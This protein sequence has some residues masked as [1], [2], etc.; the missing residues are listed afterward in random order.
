MLR[1]LLL[2]AEG[3]KKRGGRYT[4]GGDARG[5]AR[6]SHLPAATPT[7]PILPPPSVLSSYP[8]RLDNRLLSGSA[9]V[10]QGPRA[11]LPL[12]CGSPWQP[13]P[14]VRAAWAR[15]SARPGCATGPTG[16][17]GA[18][19][20]NAV[21]ASSKLV[22]TNLRFLQALR[23]RGYF[24]SISDFA[25]VACEPRER[26]WRDHPPEV[27]AWK[28]PPYGVPSYEGHSWRSYIP[29]NPSVLLQPAR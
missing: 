25:H 14:L 17:P 15:E 18:R 4:G 23:A 5:Q 9:R 26:R 10:G 13:P 22:P 11:P 20:K 19:V 7:P 6:T 27:V 29:P 24:M 2:L 3:G 16:M 28:R 21:E 1:L 12:T 8:R